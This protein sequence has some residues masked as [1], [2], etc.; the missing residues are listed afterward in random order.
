MGKYSSAPHSDPTSK[1]RK[2][3]CASFVP[4]LHSLL[5]ILLIQENSMTLLK[6]KSMIPEA[7]GT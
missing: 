2:K 3:A 6:S 7:S 1:L 5:P 4:E